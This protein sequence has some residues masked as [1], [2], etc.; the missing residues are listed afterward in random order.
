MNQPLKSASTRRCSHRVERRLRAREVPV[1]ED[2]GGRAPPEAP[3]HHDLAHAVEARAVVEVEHVAADDRRA[4]REVAEGDRADDALGLA[5]DV[6]VH[7][8][9]V[10]RGAAL[11]RLHLAARV[12]AGATEVALLDHLEGLAQEALGLG[13][14]LRAGDLVGALVDDQHP[15]EVGPQVLVLADLAQ[16]LGAEVG[17]VHRGDADGDRAVLGLVLGHLGG[18]LGR[19]HDQVGVAG[20]HVVPVPAA[21]GEGL[22]RQLELEGDLA[23]LGVVTAVLVGAARLDPLRA[24]VGH[25]AVDGDGGGAAADRRRSG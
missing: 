17:A 23:A 24:A 9:E 10:R 7:A 18:P 19:M 2:A 4:A 6:V 12:A 13:V 11:E 15:V 1:L 20:G 16:Q 14:D 3:G 5:D 25:R 22:E 21:V 8:H